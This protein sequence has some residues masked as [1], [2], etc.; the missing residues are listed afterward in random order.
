LLEQRKR[1]R[2]SLSISRPTI[3]TKRPVSSAGS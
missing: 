1:K 2:Y 3:I